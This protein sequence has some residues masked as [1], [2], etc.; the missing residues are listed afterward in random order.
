MVKPCWGKLYS[1]VEPAVAEAALKPLCLP[2]AVKSPCGHP[3][4]TRRRDSAEVP[5]GEFMQR[6]ESICGL[7]VWSFHSLPPLTS[8]L[9]LL[10]QCVDFVF[11]LF[12]SGKF[13]ILLPIS[14]FH[15]FFSVFPWLIPSQ[16]NLTYTPLMSML[17]NP[18]F[19]ARKLLCILIFSYNFLSS[20]LPSLASP[21]RGLVPLKIAIHSS[22]P[23]GSKGQKEWSVF[24]F[25]SFPLLGEHRVFLYRFTF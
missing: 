25:L 21:W 18:L 20:S 16:Q 8:R 7:P 24:I 23:F 3:F 2:W 10:P 15:F 6:I 4:S 19:I 17:W 1:S 12:Y 13:T 22:I 5:L 14:F 9:S 11:T